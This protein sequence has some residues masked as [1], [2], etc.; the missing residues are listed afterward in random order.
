MLW[1]NASSSSGVSAEGSSRE[2]TAIMVGSR[3]SS[4]T[5][6]GYSLSVSSRL[7]WIF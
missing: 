4:E 6:W 5:D 3:I 2:L 7:R 1:T